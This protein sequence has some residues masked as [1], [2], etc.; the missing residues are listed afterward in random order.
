MFESAPTSAPA[1][2][3][4]AAH[5]F[6]AVSVARA[7]DSSSRSGHTASFQSSYSRSHAGT[8]TSANARS[9]TGVAPSARNFSWR[10]RGYARKAFHWVLPRPQTR[11]RQFRQT[12]APGDPCSSSILNAVAFAGG[13]EV[14][15]ELIATSSHGSCEGGGVPASSF[16]VMTSLM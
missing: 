7:P 3:D 1:T 6:A 8:P 11:Y 12:S 10:Y 13:F 4:S 5:R 14:Y 15:V 9:A 2:A 16:I